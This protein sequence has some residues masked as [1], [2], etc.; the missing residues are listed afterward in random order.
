MDETFLKLSA[1]YDEMYAE[2]EA[3]M[4]AL[5]GKVNKFS[6]SEMAIYVTVAPELQEYADTWI[7]ELIVKYAKKR[8][9]IMRQDVFIGVK[10]ILLEQQG[11]D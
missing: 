10:T 8:R 7:N 5:N 4:R 1:L 9:V 3:E 2:L 11:A 6:Y